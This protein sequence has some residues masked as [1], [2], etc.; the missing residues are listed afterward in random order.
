MTTITQQIDPLST[1]PSRSDPTNFDE[2]AD[3]FLSE[4]PTATEQINTLASQMNDVAQEMNESA[5]NAI[6]AQAGAEAARDLAIS[7]A[8]ATVYDES[9]SYSFPDTVI[10]VDGNAYRCLGDGITGVDPM[11]D[12]GDKWAR[13]TDAGVVGYGVRWDTKNDVMVRGIYKNG[14]FYESTV[15]SFP[16]QEKMRRCVV[17]DDGTVAYYLHQDDSTKKADGTDANL[18]GA[19]GQV[20]VEIPAF[21]SAVLES[22]DFQ[23]FL[24]GEFPF[25]GSCIDP[26]FVRD[27]SVL[28]TRYI[29]AFEGV[30]FDASAGEYV[31]GNGSSLADTT[32]DKISSIPGFKP[33]TN[34]TRA[35]FRELCK[36]GTAHLFDY[37]LYRAIL[38][39]FVTEYATWDSQSVL[40][41]YTS[42]GSWSYSYV[43]QTG[44]TLSMGNNSGSY[45]DGTRYVANT[46]RGIENVFGHIWKFVDGINFDSYD[47]YLCDN[48]DNFVD[49][50]S[51][52]Y[53]QA[54]D[55]YGD[56]I[57]IPSG[58]GYQKNLWAGSL[59]PKSIGGSSITF[60]TDY[61]YAVNSG[62]RVLLAG[63]NLSIGDQAGLA[64]L[65]F[66]NDSSSRY[67]YSGARSAA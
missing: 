10:C 26:A 58:E 6:S 66:T 34:Q 32:S 33:W 13:L 29:G 30:L 64:C 21:Y 36:N 65:A 15:T 44:L 42:M 60:I 7:A 4:L 56:N 27:G 3:Q 23:Y 35:E 1:P 46:Y 20:M 67:S 24:V 49:D 55:L 53:T 54:I 62:W 25:E 8:S 63:G 43:K 45:H 39:L 11:T 17:Q 5:A 16:I 57:V 28:A 59:L 31:D 14:V 38:L 9:V 51:T 41:G 61:L 52:N 22:G 50:S 37:Y 47:I 40:P 48:P 12:G 2:R 18:S 19:D